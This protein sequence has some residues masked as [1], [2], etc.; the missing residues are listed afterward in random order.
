MR[1]FKR[2]EKT[3]LEI[4]NTKNRPQRYF[5]MLIGVFLLA[6]AFNLFFLPREIVYGGI[7]GISIIINYLFQIEPALF[8]LIASIFLLL[9]SWILLGKEQTAK[10]VIGSIIFPIFVKL[11]EDFTYLINLNELE[12]LIIVL[13]G[14][15]IA[16][17]GAGLV[18][19]AG[20]TTGGTDIINQIVAKYF[21]VSIGKAM[22]MTDGLIVL[23]GGFFFGV[24]KVLYAIIVLYIISVMTDKVIL[25]V[26]QS[27]AFYIMTNKEHEVKDYI[28]NNLSH[29]L[30]VLDAHGGYTNSRTKVLMCVIPTKE[31]FSFKEGIEII[32]KDAFFV[33]SDAYEVGGVYK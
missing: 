20:F 33:V 30:T 29:G 1:L 28:L 11:T 10:T 21:K 31:Y 17:F 5:S 16:G 3:I 2:K 22:L 14:A 23:A 15:L 12:M 32:D 24:E 4:I 8:I 6:I 13:F 9:L 18:F 25:G 26:S 27:K 19:K 7:S